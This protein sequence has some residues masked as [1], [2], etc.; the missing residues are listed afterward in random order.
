MTPFGALEWSIARRY[1]RARRRE[2]AISVVSSLSI[3]GIVLGVAAL[4]I[5]MSVMNGF[6]TELFSR[7]LG[8]S[9]HVVVQAADGMPGYDGLA[10]TLE[11]VDGVTRAVPYVLGQAYATGNGGASGVLLRGVSKRN[12][13]RTPLLEKHLVAGS[14]D[15]FGEGKGMVIGAGLARSLGVTIGDKVTVM[16]QDG[17][18]TPFGQTPQIDNYPVLAIFD[19]GMSQVDGTIAYLPIAE[20]QLFLNMDERATGIEIFS[21]TPDDMDALKAAIARAADRPLYLSDWR[22]NNRAYYTALTVERNVMFIILTLIVLVASMNVISSMTMLVN[23]KTPD[24]AIMRTIGASRGTVLRV[25]LMVGLTIGVGGTLIGLALGTLIAVNIEAIRQA[26]T[27]IF[28]IQLFP[29]E[30]YYLTQIPSD[31]SSTQTAM[32]VLISLILA[33]IAT[34]PPAWKAAATDPVEALKAE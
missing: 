1:L 34:V 32:V 3:T 6:R 20:A 30:L 9:G 16:T 24:I 27:T 18:V 21:E 23:E 31:I 8:I 15:E 22:Q 13:E 17:P 7:I 33:L 12:M 14:L 10:D 28:N 19:V 5:V 29:P 25:F 4:I 26:I 2:R 11:G